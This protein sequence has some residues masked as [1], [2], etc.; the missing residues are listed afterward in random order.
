MATTESAVSRRREQK[1]TATGGEKGW[2]K[3][4]QDSSRHR[5]RKKRLV[6]ARGQT[7]VRGTTDRTG[8][9]FNLGARGSHEKAGRATPESGTDRLSDF[10]DR[11]SG[12]DSGL[13]NEAYDVEE[14]GQNVGENGSLGGVRFAEPRRVFDAAAG[15]VSIATFGVA[16][17]AH[18]Q[19]PGRRIDFE[20]ASKTNVTIG[21]REIDSDDTTQ[22]TFRVSI[23]T[24]SEC[25]I[26]VRMFVLDK[27]V[28]DVGCRVVKAAL[29]T[30]PLAVTSLVVV[31]IEGE[32]VTV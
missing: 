13:P 16:L 18:T 21:K 17:A 20:I 26:Y 3:G 15:L 12:I 29:A 27:V 25:R 5:I 23:G 31:T 8:V 28:G 1:S 4:Q 14:A 22:G 24:S 2:R 32:S 9:L 7:I 30:D 11:A 19:F 6:D 10:Q